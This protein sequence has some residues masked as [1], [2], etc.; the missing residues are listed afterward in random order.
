MMKKI[1]IYSVLFILCLSGQTQTRIKIWKNTTVKSNWSELTIYKPDSSKNNHTAIIICPGGSYHHL[2]MKHEGHAVAKKFAREGFTAFVL[3]YR[4]GMFSYKHPAMIQDIQR[5]IALVKENATCFNVFED[6]VG[7]IGFSA[8]G[9]LVGSAATYFEE[10]S[11]EPLGIKPKV[12]LKPF[13]TVMMYPVVTM[14]KPYAHL[15][16]RKNLIGN[17]AS[18]SLEA[19][20]SLEKN[21]H[22]NMSNILIIQAQNDPV[23]DYHNSVLLDQALKTLKINHKLILHQTGGHGFGAFPAPNSDMKN[24]FED[25]LNWLKT[26]KKED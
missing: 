18:D 11:M 10:N 1:F 14:Y 13:F 15:K 6:Q 12:S 3:R 7:L 8:G 21:V 17:K 5:S 2:G 16:S 22:S 9:H 25:V 19:K 4:V 26:I 20:M 24:W 23:V